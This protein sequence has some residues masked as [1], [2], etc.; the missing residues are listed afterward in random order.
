MSGHGSSA[1]GQPSGATGGLSQARLVSD[2]SPQAAAR[3]QQRP[4]ETWKTY[5]TQDEA[6]T[7]KLNTY[8]W[9]NEVGCH[10]SAGAELHGR[11]GSSAAF[12]RFQWVVHK[13][14]PLSPEALRS[15]GL[16]PEA[17]SSVVTGLKP[18]VNTLEE[19][20]AVELAAQIF[21]AGQ[22][23]AAVRQR[24]EE[25][26]RRSIATQ[27]S[28]QQAFDAERRRRLALKQTDLYEAEA[29]FVAS[30]ASALRIVDNRE[31]RAMLRTAYDLGWSHGRDEKSQPSTLELIHRTALTDTYLPRVAK[32]VDGLMVE[33]FKVSATRGG[34]TFG[35]DGW[36]DPSGD[37]QSVSTFTT[38]TESHLIRIRD[39]TRDRKNEEYFLRCTLEDLDYIFT[40][41]GMVTIIC[42][43]GAMADWHPALRVKLRE[44]YPGL[45]IL[46]LA[47]AAHGVSLFF[48]DIFGIGRSEL[49]L[50][51]ANGSAT[52]IAHFLVEVKKVVNFIMRHSTLKGIFLA[53]PDSLALRLPQEQRMG[54]GFLLLERYFKDKR[55]IKELFNHPA[56]I[57]YVTEDSYGKR[58]KSEYQSL[59]EENIE[60]NLHWKQVH[61]AVILLEPYYKLLRRCDTGTPNLPWVAMAFHNA[62]VA[63]RQLPTMADGGAFIEV[64]TAAEKDSIIKVA[65]ERNEYTIK[66]EHRA[67]ALLNPHYYITPGECVLPD[68][69]VGD[70]ALLLENLY[71]G[72]ANTQKRLAI[73]DLLPRMWLHE[74]PF[75]NEDAWAAAAK[76][77]LDIAAWYNMYCI[78][79]VG[80]NTVDMTPLRE[81]G[82]LV[83]AGQCS[84]GQTER[85][86]KVISRQL[87]KPRTLLTNEHTQ[88]LSRLGHWYQQRNARYR[89]LVIDGHNHVLDKPRLHE[90]TLFAVHAE[91][92]REQRD[93]LQAERD[94][95]LRQR[96]ADPDFMPPEGGMLDLLFNGDPEAAC[97]IDHNGDIARI[98]AAAVQRA[99]AHRAA[100]GGPSDAGA[101]GGSAATAV[102]APSRT[103][104]AAGPQRPL[105]E[106]QAEQLWQMRHDNAAWERP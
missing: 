92:V 61:K 94:D 71:P 84:A 26:A 2:R 96:A 50:T 67:A 4:V 72:V 17:V 95:F 60:N 25:T 41:G 78:L 99:N 105:E 36:K 39:S 30:T 46:V 33:S 55:F 35:Y 104:A 66:A 23:E 79:P 1:A 53:I 42:T 97:V 89:A 75:D 54:S 28:L 38:A 101:A 90:S 88:Q 21:K 81:V 3:K 73:R 77:E 12:T 65:E 5:I 27:L 80:R 31:F 45:P 48:K 9:C 14:R 64:Y 37:E 11:K 86:N 15:L 47:C 7:N 24:R 87:T 44:K 57:E 19:D 32:R 16:D 43:D 58:Y 18:C 40:H 13:L 91:A 49:S 51:H 34:G 100:T 69:W 83:G 22:E 68:S 8:L 102:N 93:K 56:V 98:L 6:R 20:P 52:W 29:A 62:L 10:Y 85:I 82:V 70:L 106:A 59:Y 103:P 63:S 74:T 76:K